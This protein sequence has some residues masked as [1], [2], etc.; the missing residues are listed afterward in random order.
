LSLARP[1]GGA[2][3]TRTRSANGA[4]VTHRSMLRHAPSAYWDPFLMP[5]C[6]PTA[7]H[8]A[9]DTG[10][11]LPVTPRRWAESLAEPVDRSHGS[12]IGHLMRGRASAQK[13]L[14]ARALVRGDRG[15]AIAIA[16]VVLPRVV[17]RRASQPAH[18][19]LR[20]LA[21]RLPA[22][23][24]L[25]LDAGARGAGRPPRHVRART[26]QPQPAPLVPEP[27]PGLAADAP[28]P[29]EHARDDGCGVGG[30]VLLRGKAARVPSRL[31]RVPVAGF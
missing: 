1:R 25:R 4:G 13:C 10:Q 11:M 5:P 16:V 2:P 19:T 26:D 20:G 8:V 15:R 6:T 24:H 22:L 9:V 28:L 31:C 14:S 27:G 30:A 7:L 23:D 17:R 29:A 3:S 21:S 18:R 12:G